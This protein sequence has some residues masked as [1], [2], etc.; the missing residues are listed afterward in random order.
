MGPIE[1]KQQDNGFGTNHRKHYIH[2]RK[3]PNRPNEEV[4]S[5]RLPQLYTA[6]KKLSSNTNTQ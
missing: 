4:E 6:S 2:G 3:W 1:I 5:I